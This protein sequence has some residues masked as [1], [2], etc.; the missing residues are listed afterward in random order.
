MSE[1]GVELRETRFLSLFEWLPRADGER[2]HKR[3]ER[4]RET[5]RREK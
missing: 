1:R 4:E 2:A 5:Q 3:R